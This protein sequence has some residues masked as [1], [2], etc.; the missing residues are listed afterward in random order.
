[1]IHRLKL[2]TVT[3]VD[4]LTVDD[5]LQLFPYILSAPLVAPPSSQHASAAATSFYWTCAEIF[6]HSH[7]TLK[8]A[9][10]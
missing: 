8:T 2:T 6:D 9:A 5:R 3:S 4:Q 1:M 10:S 7:L